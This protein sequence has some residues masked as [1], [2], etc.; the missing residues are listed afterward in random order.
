MSGSDVQFVTATFNGNP[1]NASVAPPAVYVG[2][3]P[4]NTGHVTI[5]PWYY[6]DVGP[7]QIVI[8]VDNL[9]SNET[10]INIT[11]WVQHY[12]EGLQVD[13]LPTHVRRHGQV[14]FNVTVTQGNR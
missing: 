13:V 2:Q 11:I 8:T 7:Y 6:T 3:G 10:T 4:D 1:M 5:Y 9:V 14:E 12:I